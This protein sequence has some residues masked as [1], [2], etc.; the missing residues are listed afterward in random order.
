[1][2]QYKQSNITDVY[3]AM[4]DGF[5]GGRDPMGIQNSSIATYACLLPG[6]TNLTGHIRYYSFYC[7][8]LSEYDKLEING[9]TSVHQ[10]NFI[11]RA[12]L[13]MAFIMKNQSENSVVGSLFISQEKYH[14]VENDVYDLKNGGDYESKEKYW[15]FKTGAFGQYYL[16]SLIHFK[17]VKI[18]ENRFYLRDKGKELAV[19]FCSSV[20]KDVRDLFLDCIEN[21]TITEDKIEQLLPLALNKLI[22]GTDEWNVLNL[23]LT[24]PDTN[25]TSLRADTIL[26]MLRD[27]ENGITLKDFVKNRFQEYCKEQFSEA[28]FGWYFYYL[29]EALHYCIESIFCFVLTE[30]D[31]M[32]N[33]SVGLFMQQTVDDILSCFEEE[34]LYENMQEWQY[35]CHEDITVMWES[36][37]YEIKEKEYAK[38]VARAIPLLLRLNNE[39]EENKEEI[40]NFEKKNDLLRQRGILSEGLKSYVTRYLDLS[41]SQ[42]VS[43]VIKQVMNEHTFVAIAKMGNS[44]VDLRKFI[45]EEGRLVLVEIRYPNET[46]P[47]TSSLYNFLY[48]MKYLEADDALTDL[49]YQFIN[50]YGD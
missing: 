49:A 4:N 13:A 34:Q 1:M 44:N 17:L 27:L 6:L 21:G 23:M 30:I 24:T 8:L 28:S 18:E 2:S 42:Y 45:F 7:W 35:D 47:R 26:L 29:C 39:F 9:E 36:L 32:H 43:S 12:E 40:I 20:S 50:N 31:I 10:Y 11:R 16:G 25:G 33:P 19:A 41:L 14:L 22:V 3:W 48:D 37:K 38:A 5:K 15:T 46:N